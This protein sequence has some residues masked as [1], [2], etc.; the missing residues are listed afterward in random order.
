LFL[1]LEHAQISPLLDLGHVVALETE[2]DVSPHLARK[3][4]FFNLAVVLKVSE[5]L[6][7]VIITQVSHFVGANLRLESKIEVGCLSRPERS[8]IFAE[9]FME[10][11]VLVQI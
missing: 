6:T 8:L 3:E 2:P 7:D 11:L 1:Q 4:S 9:P 10:G 5:L